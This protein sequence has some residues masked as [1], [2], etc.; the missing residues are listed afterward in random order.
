MPRVDERGHALIES[1]VLGLVLLV[2]VVWMLSVFA[3]LHAAA[4]ATTSAAREAGFEAARASDS[5]SAD[6]AIARLVSATVADHDLDPRLATVRWTPVEGWRRGG[7]I[8]V[9]VAYEV[10][11][12]Q[13]PL[14]GQITDPAIPVNASHVATLDRYRSRDV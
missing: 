14:L 9:V 8:Q 11:V 6:R 3:D 7:T 5:V 4:L 1:I 2:P 12:F 13:A 10:P